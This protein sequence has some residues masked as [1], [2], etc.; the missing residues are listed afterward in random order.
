MMKKSLLVTNRI[1][2]KDT[3]RTNRKRIQQC[4]Q[5]HDGKEFLDAERHLPR[6]LKCVTCACSFFYL[7]K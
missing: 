3:C 2:I 6:T 5:R 4:F 1:T 7:A